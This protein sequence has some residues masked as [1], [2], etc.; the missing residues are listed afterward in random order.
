MSLISDLF[1]KYFLHFSH[2]QLNVCDFHVE[3]TWNAFTCNMCG[4]YSIEQIGNQEI[5]DKKLY[6]FF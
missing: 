2:W 3:K 1:L 5:L 6:I 4:N